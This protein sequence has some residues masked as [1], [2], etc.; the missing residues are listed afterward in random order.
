MILRVPLARATCDTHMARVATRWHN[1]FGKRV[2]A[3]SGMLCLPALRPRGTRILCMLLKFLFIF[4]FSSGSAVG[5]VDEGNLLR[6]SSCTPIFQ[7]P[8]APN[9]M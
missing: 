6:E 2:A 3:D 5:I 1:D 9:E 8:V 4:L 7:E